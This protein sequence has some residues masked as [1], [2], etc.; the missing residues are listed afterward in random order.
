VLFFFFFSSRR[1]HTRFSR[2]WSSDVCSSDLAR[3]SAHDHPAGAG[4][5][6]VGEDVGCD[7]AVSVPG[8][9]YR[10][11]GSGFCRNYQGFGRDGMERAT[12]LLLLAGSLA[13]CASHSAGG[14]PWLGER[15]V[16]VTRQCDPL[17]A[18]QELVLGL[19]GEMASAGRRHAALANLERLPGDLPQV[20]L[21]K[22]RLLR[23]L[24]HGNEAETLY[25]SLLGSC[26]SAQANHGLGQIEASRAKHSEAQRYLRTASALAPADS[27][28]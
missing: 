23:I 16:G 10:T 18:D 1:R 25:R 2:D 6:D 13:G 17:T 12:A 20:R 11:G 14:A 22:A 19:S 4:L 24:G 9:A 26:L 21:H 8:A 15:E 3:R 7:D 5:Q 28:I 27:A